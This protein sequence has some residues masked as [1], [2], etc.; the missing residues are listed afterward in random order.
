M[1]KG[2]WNDCSGISAVSWATHYDSRLEAKDI[3]IGLFAGPPQ[4]FGKHEIQFGRN[5]APRLPVG[6]CR[7]ADIGKRRGYRVSTN[8]LY[9]FLDR[10]EHAK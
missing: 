10:I 7:A 5:A 3:G 6:H 8:P 9:D 1:R 4:N 2:V